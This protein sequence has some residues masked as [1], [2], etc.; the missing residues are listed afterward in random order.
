MIHLAAVV[1][2]VAGLILCFGGYKFF[3]A[4]LTLVGF[5]A[6]LLLTVAI[7]YAWFGVTEP[8]AWGFGL[9]GGLLGAVLVSLLYVVG[10]FVLGA[11]FGASVG[12]VIGLEMHLEPAALMIVFAIVGGVL[13]LLVQKFALVLATAGLGASFIVVGALSFLGRTTPNLLLSDPFAW[14][15]VFRGQGVVFVVWLILFAVGILVQSKNREK[16]Q[17]ERRDKGK[18]RDK[19]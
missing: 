3:R 17:K 6:G 1:L 14:W 4:L 7:A 5:V 16:T 13:A 18:K 19:N 2:L 12:S 11:L 9:I 8:A 15:P 10:V